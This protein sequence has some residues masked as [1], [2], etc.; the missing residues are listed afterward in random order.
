MAMGFTRAKVIRLFTIE[1]A[2]HAVLAALVAALY[3]IPFLTWFAKTGWPLPESMDSYGF[4]IGE[5]IFPVYSA[6]LVVGTT[7][8]ILVVTTLVSFLPTRKIAKLKPTD[9]LRGKTS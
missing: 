6:G 8:L 7:L 3:G 5:K 2:M 9:A 1:G 4:A